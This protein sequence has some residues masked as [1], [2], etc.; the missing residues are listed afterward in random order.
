MSLGQQIAVF[1]LQS[2]KLQKFFNL[3]Q[4]KKNDYSEKKSINK[5]NNNKN[6]EH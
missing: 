5:I 4:K 3:T 2:Q 1:H 6:F